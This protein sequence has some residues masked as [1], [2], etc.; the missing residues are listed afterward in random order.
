MYSSLYT[1]YLIVI[2]LVTLAK[3]VMIYPLI[4]KYSY[5]S[6][7]IYLIL[8]TVNMLQAKCLL[9]A[10]LKLFLLSASS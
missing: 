8:S 1:L 2:Y 7:V 3:Q 6:E 9:I 4:P 10:H 5:I